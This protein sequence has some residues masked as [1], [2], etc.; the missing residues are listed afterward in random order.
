MVV[1]GR[2]LDDGDVAIMMVEAGGTEAVVAG[3]RGRRPQ[4]DRS[5]SS[6][7]ASR[8]PRPG[9][10]TRSSCS[11]SWS[12]GRGRQAPDGLHGQSDYSPE[13][14]AAVQEVGAD[15]L[16]ETQKLVRQGRAPRRRGRGPRRH[17]RRAGAPLRRAAR[18]PPSRSRRPFRSTTKA[19][20]RTRIVNEG[21]RID[22]RGVTDIRPAVGRGRRAPDGARLRPVPAG[23]DPGAER[24][25]ARHAPHGADARHARRGRPQALHAP[26]QLPAVLDR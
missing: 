4:G 26:L 9:S 23:R 25:H 15:R 24:H 13:V 5:R 6:P 3:L 7:R 10:A 12:A 16:A 18:T 2:L 21:L 17:H 14:F 8:P 22:G 1:A 19:M 11:A 20:V